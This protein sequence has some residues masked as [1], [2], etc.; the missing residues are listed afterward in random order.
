M[1]APNTDL[2][3]V[4]SLAAAGCNVT[5]FTTG[6]GTPVGSPVSITLKITATQQTFEDMEEN[7]DLCVAGV[8]DGRESI[9]AAA[10]RVVQAVVDM[11]NGQPAKAER[12]GHWEVAIPIRG[13]TY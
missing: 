1:N 10:K 6:R 11:A 4:T 8:I 12:L 5:I 7:I 3:C 2:E 13:V 9:D